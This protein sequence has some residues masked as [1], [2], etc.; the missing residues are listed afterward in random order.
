[1]EL[2]RKFIKGVMN[3]DVDERLLPDGEYIDAVNVDVINSEGSDAGTIR[4]IKGNA[5]VSDLDD[6]TNKTVANARTIGAVADEANNKIYWFVTS[7]N[8]DGVYEYDETT[9]NTARVLE[10]ATGKL[11]FDADYYITGVNI[12]DGFLYWTDNLNPPRS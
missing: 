6:V 12:I 7:D 9:G 5:I 2:K 3:K 1:M 11:N 4:N 10:S 8:F